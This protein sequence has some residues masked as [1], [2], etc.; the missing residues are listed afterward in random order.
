MLL[1]V[2]NI[3]NLLSSFRLVAAPFLLFIASQN[4]PKLFLTL[5]AVSLMTDAVDGFVA[6]RC[7]VTSKTGVK[8][9]SW[10]DFITFITMA[11]SS[12][13]LWPDILEREIF[14]VITGITSFLLP[15]AVGLIKFKNLPC[16]HTWAAK[17]Q[18]VFICSAIFILFVTGNALLFRCAVV[19]QIFVS[20]E[21]IIIT[22]CL[23]EQKYNVPSLWHLIHSQS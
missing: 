7:K 8:L 19:L 15:V 3:P 5:L 4:M 20:I 22:F 11:V 2:E 12:W 13:W 23:N 18:A 17:I 14:F 21:E 9:D 6:R 10:A 16:Y 1:T